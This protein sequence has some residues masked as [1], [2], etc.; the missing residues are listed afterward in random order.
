MIVTLL[1]TVLTSALGL[2]PTYDPPDFGD[3]GT[4]L[5]SALA[6][7]NALFPITTLGACLAVIVGFRLFLLVWDAIV[8]LYRLIPLKAT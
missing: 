4:S 7:A 3:L 2:L 6:A 5:G 8:W 1:L